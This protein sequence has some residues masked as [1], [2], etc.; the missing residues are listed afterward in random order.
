MRVMELI[1]IFPVITG[2]LG[3]E[4]EFG[5]NCTL[6]ESTHITTEG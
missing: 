6:Y 2:K 4:A 5:G 3:N 1:Q